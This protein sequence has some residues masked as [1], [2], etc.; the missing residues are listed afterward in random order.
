MTFF[1]EILILLV[2]PIPFFDFYIVFK[3]KKAIMVVYFL[4]EILTSLMSL[5]VYFFV[6]T[7]YNFSIY[8][9]PFSK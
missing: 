7:F 8:T 2:C 5:R 1:F 4:S 3:S 6:R 9:D